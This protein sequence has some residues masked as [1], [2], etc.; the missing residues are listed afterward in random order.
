[1]PPEFSQVFYAQTPLYA[2]ALAWGLLGEKFSALSCCGIALFTC[3]L[4]V[5]SAPDAALARVGL[6]LGLPPPADE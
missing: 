6:P 2:A 1:M 3:S 4:A 5:A